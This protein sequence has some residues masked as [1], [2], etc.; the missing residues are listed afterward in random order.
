[1]AAPS[2]PETAGR[3]AAGMVAAYAAQ[4][5]AYREWLALAR[6]AQERLRSD[7]L[8]EFL[9]LHAQK[10][11]LTGRLHAMDRQVQECRRGLGAYVGNSEPTLEHLR[12][13]VGQ[14]QDAAF[15]EA[16]ADLPRVL[17][18]LRAV[19][20]ELQAVEADTE[21]LLRK[22]LQ[23]LRAD[24]TQ[25]QAARRATR[26]YGQPDPVSEREPRFIDHQG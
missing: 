4:L 24:I 5:D 16:V 11:A 15:A 23:G 25:T 7:D 9:R 22:R 6:Q 12:A 2:G 20:Q 21:Q 8:D 10:E 19:M 3:L 1:V 26:A 14:L 17:D 13:A 18:Q